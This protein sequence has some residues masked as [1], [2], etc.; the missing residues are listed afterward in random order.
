MLGLPSCHT[1]VL[2]YGVQA[3]GSA[4]KLMVHDLFLEQVGKVCNHE[5]NETVKA[6]AAT[7][8]F[9]EF[10]LHPCPATDSDMKKFDVNKR[11]W[12]L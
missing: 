9:G 3:N 8:F 11:E 5:H 12:I 7:A 2:I 6:A 4:R 1:Y 10:P